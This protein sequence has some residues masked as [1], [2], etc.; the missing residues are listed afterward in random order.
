MKLDLI[1]CAESAA[2]DAPTNRLSLFN[3][4]EEFTGQIF[5]SIVPSLTLIVVTTREAREPEDLELH[6]KIRV[7]SNVIYENAIR[8]NFQGK[9]RVRAITNISGLPI[10]EPGKVVFSVL[11]GKRLLGDWTIIV[12]SAPSVIQLQRTSSS[13]AKKTT[14]AVSPASRTKGKAAKKKSAK[15]KKG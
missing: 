5:P 6:V 3:L 2:I 11:H 7:N 13:A 15:K 4:L 10:M 9:M 12:N 14:I 1:A 8:A